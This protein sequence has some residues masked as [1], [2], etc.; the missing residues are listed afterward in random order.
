VRRT[1]DEALAT[2]EQLLDAALAVFTRK[3]YASTTLQDVAHEAG[4]TRGAVYWHFDG[5]PAL[6]EALIRERSGPLVALWGSMTDGG[7]PALAQLERLLRDQLAL[8]AG[9]P[10]LRALMTLNWLQTERIPELEPGFQRKIAGIHGLLTALAALIA[11]GIAAGEIEAGVDPEAT[12]LAALSLVN[13]ATSLALIDPSLGDPQRWD[14]MISR[15]I[16][17]LRA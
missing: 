4:T 12:A 3:G 10:V 1:K 11:R 2:R 17:D 16:E 13:G 9:D 5:K 6:Y 15:F 14:R 7:A 8:V